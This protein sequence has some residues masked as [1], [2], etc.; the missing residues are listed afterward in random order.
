MLK[1]S[2]L[3]AVVVAGLFAAAAPSLAQDYPRSSAQ[4]TAAEPGQVTIRP[5]EQ[6]RRFYMPSQD[7]AE[8]R[9]EYRMEDGQTAKVKARNRKLLV[10]FDNR[11]TKLEAVGAYVF[12]SD[13]DDMTLVYTKDSM[14]YDVIVVS[15]IPQQAV[16]GLPQKRV[17][18]SS[19]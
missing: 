2:S 16:A 9:G 7:V 18:L 15:Y 17:M 6:M 19:R 5:R 3:F 13:H 14:G 10:D 11:I 4:A 8:V 12:E 1:L